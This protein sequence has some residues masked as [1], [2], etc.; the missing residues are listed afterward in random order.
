MTDPRHITLEEFIQLGVKEQR[1]VSLEIAR[2]LDEEVAK[3][4]PREKVQD[5][6]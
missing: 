5:E 6:V 4:S 2:I 1:A 3:T